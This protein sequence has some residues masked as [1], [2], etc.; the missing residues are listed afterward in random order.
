MRL[1]AERQIALAIIAKRAL[2]PK[3]KA[4]SQEGRGKNTK[5]P[6]PTV[7]L[8]HDPKDKEKSISLYKTESQS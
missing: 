1:E 7:S 4:P 5:T 3:K 6:S 2:A 8:Q